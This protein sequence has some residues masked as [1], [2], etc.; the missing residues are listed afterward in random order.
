MAEGDSENFFPE[1][2][3][4]GGEAMAVTGD[5]DDNVISILLS[6]FGMLTDE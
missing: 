1:S 4:E 6:C 3:K 5:G 2:S